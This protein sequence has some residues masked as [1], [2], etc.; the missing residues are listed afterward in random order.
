MHA[1]LWLPAEKRKLQ[2]HTA[3][4]G[5]HLSPTCA[6]GAALPAHLLYRVLQHMVGSESPAVD[7][8]LD[9]VIAS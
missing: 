1:L 5:A 7:Q 2:A 9:S 3:E 8:D 6:V 4:P